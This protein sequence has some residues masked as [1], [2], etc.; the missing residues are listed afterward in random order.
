MSASP[1]IRKLPIPDNLCDK[2]IQLWLVDLRTFDLTADYKT[3]LSSEEWRR[4]A[5][6]RLE[7]HRKQFTVARTALRDILSRKLACEPTE[8]VFEYGNAG[9]PE[10]RLPETT[11]KF[12]VSHSE[13]ITVIALSDSADVGIDVEKP[14]AE[15]DILAVGH[16]VFCPLELSQLEKC[17]DSE[18]IQLFYQLWTAKEAMLKMLGAGFTLPLDEFCIIHELLEGKPVKLPSKFVNTEAP[19]CIHVYQLDVGNACY[20]ALATSVD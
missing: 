15:I 4:A 14:D 13:H 19:E 10:I 11:L 20:A 3:S 1:G 6:Y 16:M 2:G 18:R 5:R 12:S 8:I 7:S 17:T 9:R